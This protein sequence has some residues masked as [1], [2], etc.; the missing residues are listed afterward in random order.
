MPQV[1]FKLPAPITL[2]NPP[3][4]GEEDK[5]RP[6]SLSDMV[7]H[8]GRTAR[9]YNADMDGARCYQRTQ[10]A[11][12]GAA[13][14]GNVTLQI[15]DLLVLHEVSEKPTR[16]WANTRASVKQTKVDARGDEQTRFVETRVSLPAVT[17]LPLVDPIAIAA[18]P[19]VTTP[20]K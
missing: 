3:K 8:F 2:G 16:G 10:R 5:R 4:E 20:A 13:E 15:E 18:A 6:Y 11:V 14:T 9:E 19:F 17:F 7:A 1:T 12:D